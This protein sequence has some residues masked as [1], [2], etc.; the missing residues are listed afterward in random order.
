MEKMDLS[1]LF[2]KIAALALKLP[3]YV[4]KVRKPAQSTGA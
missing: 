2:Q 3:E 4:M 1:A